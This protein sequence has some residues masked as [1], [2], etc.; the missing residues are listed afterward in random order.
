MASL[1]DR[2]IRA[3]TAAPI[4][5]HEPMDTITLTKPPYFD[6]HEVGRELAQM[7]ETHGGVE[8]ARPHVLSRLKAL[9]RMARED[10]ER[11][12]L[13][14]G[15]RSC[16]AGLSAFQDALLA[17]VYDY[18]VT[19]AYSAENPSSAEHMAVVATG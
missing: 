9:L 18:T 6:S 2:G 14:D 15:G 3:R 13:A 8:R 5:L 17:L 4:R 10:A 16:A 1:A 12:L 11:Q 7:V 19:Q